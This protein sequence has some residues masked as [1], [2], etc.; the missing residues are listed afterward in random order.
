MKSIVDIFSGQVYTETSMMRL[1]EDG[2][3]FTKIGDNYIASDGELIVKQGNYL[4]NT[5]TGIMSN[6]G[7]PFLEEE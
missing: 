6:F 3:V 5:K 2:R 7:D 4:L 1:T